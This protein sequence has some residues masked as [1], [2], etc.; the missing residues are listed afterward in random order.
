M[1]KKGLEEQQDKYANKDILEA[2]MITVVKCGFETWAPRKAE[3]Y[4]LEVFPEKLPT[5]SFG[6]QFG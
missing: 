5:D 1:A 6:H 2:T 4:L 3:K